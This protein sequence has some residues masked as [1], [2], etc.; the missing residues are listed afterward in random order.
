M[1]VD[2][3]PGKILRMRIRAFACVLILLTGCTS[4]KRLIDAPTAATVPAP[5][6]AKLELVLRDGQKITV[7]NAIVRG[8]SLLADRDPTSKE[9]VE[10]P[11]APWRRTPY[12]V[13]PPT[14]AK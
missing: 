14:S 8:D 11:N 9:R 7:H 4:M 10:N 12:A 5:L 2:E 13:A 3:Q 1:R 6:P